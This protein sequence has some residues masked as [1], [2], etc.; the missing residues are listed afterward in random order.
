MLFAGQLILAS[1]IIFITVVLSWDAGVRY[2]S[3]K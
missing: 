2:W 3:S 1:I